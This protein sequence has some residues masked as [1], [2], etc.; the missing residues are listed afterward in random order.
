MRSRMPAVARSR[1]PRT[2]L[3]PRLT[4]PLTLLERRVDQWIAKLKAE[5]A[6]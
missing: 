5:K 3:T 6:A 2:T 4:L 1:A